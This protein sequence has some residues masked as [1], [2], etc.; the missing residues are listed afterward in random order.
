MEGLLT[1]TLHIQRAATE[2]DHM[3]LWKGI[4]FADS[5][6]DYHQARTGRSD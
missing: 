2:A 5:A 6:R 4:P 1:K 3:I